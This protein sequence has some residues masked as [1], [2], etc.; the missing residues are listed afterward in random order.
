MIP[1]NSHLVSRSREE[2]KAKVSRSWQIS[3]TAPLLFYGRGRVRRMH[4]V[5]AH[6]Q[7]PMHALNWESQAQCGPLG[8][9]GK[10]SKYARTARDLHLPRWI[11]FWSAEILRYAQGGVDAKTHCG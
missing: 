3:D 10:S 7:S 4:G 8:A 9:P 2:L 5:W 6:A 1:K 11:D